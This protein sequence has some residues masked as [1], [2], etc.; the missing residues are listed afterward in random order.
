MTMRERGNK[1]RPIGEKEGGGEAKGSGIERA[2]DNEQVQKRRKQTVLIKYSLVVYFCKHTETKRRGRKRHIISF[3][4]LKNILVFINDL[5]ASGA[6]GECSDCVCSCLSQLHKKEKNVFPFSSL[7]SFP[8]SLHLLFHDHFL[9]LFLLHF[10]F[11]GHY[12]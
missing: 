9:I 11:I 2:K 10:C 8:S 6:H 1:T 7:C 5:S 3:P 12:I 4:M